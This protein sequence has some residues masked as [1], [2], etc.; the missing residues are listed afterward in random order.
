MDGSRPGNDL[1][2]TGSD[3]RDAL[4]ALVSG[5]PFRDI[6]TQFGVSAAAAH[7][8]TKHIRRAVVALAQENPAEYGR[9]ILNQVRQLTARSLRVLDRAEATGDLR[10]ATGAIRESRSCLELVARLQ[11]QIVDRHQHID[12]DARDQ[13]LR[14][15]IQL[16]KRMPKELRDGLQ[17]AGKWMLLND[18][19]VE[20]AQLVEEANTS[21]ANPRVE[22]DAEPPLCE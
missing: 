4:E 11:G 14:R 8:H 20:E 18:G 6:S 22:I 2:V 5:T 9:T 13:D 16:A 17:R 12:A 10:A 1:P 21:V 15:R 3:L 7:R 19:G